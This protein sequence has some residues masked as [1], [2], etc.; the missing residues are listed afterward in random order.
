[1][2][3]LKPK[4][5]RLILLRLIAA[6][7]LCLGALLGAACSDDGDGNGEGRDAFIHDAE[8]QIS[9][10]RAQ[11][12]ELR[13]DIA[14][15]DAGAEIDKQASAIE[16]RIDDAESELDGIR[17]S[18]DDEWESLKGEFDEAIGE[19]DSLLDDIG[20]ELGL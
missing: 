18:S 8:D 3:K 11:L 14:T 16:Q 12:E 17:A 19:A 9:K 15:G 13:D 7:T 1:M 10:L 5:W 2:A 4:D 20:I 6:T